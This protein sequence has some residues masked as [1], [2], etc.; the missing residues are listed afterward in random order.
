MAEKKEKVLT[1]R[2]CAITWRNETGTKKTWCFATKRPTYRQ[3][4][5]VFARVNQPT[6]G[7]T[8]D[9]PGKPERSFFIHKR[10]YH[11]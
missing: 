6:T 8:Q 11:E 10:R 1:Y 9:R 3:P 7:T 2:I 5:R 4:G